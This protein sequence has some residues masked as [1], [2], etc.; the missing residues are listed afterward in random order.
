MFELK[1]L[2]LLPSTV[3][4]LVIIWGLLQRKKKSLKLPPGRMGWPFI[5]ETFGYLKPYLATT[6]GEFMEQHISRYGKI[7]KSY[8]FGD[9]AIVS[10]DAGLNRFILQ[11][12]GRL[13]ECS[14]PSSIGGILGKWSMLV[15]VGDMHRD[16]RMISL[17]FMSTSRLRTH[18]MPEVDKH[19]LLVLRS[20]KENSIF[21]AQNEAKKFTF[22][23]MAKHIMSIDPGKP[24]TEHLRKEYITFMKGVVSAPLNL[25]GTAYNRALKSRSTILKVIEHKMIERLK[26][27][28]NDREKV[29]DGDLLGW[30][31]KHS[32]LSIEQILD[33]ILSLLFAGHETSSVSI[34]L[35]IYFL[36]ACPKAVQELREEHLE[37]VRAK[38]R[39][40]ES[41]LNW[42]DYKQMEFTQC[43]ISE[44]LR[45][46]NVVRFLHRK[47]IKDVR[48]NGYDIPCGWKVLPVVA[49]VHLDP[50][51]YDKP[52]EF[53]PW[54]WQSKTSTDS[55]AFSNM[56]TGNNFMPF[57]GGPRLCAGSELAKL[58]MAVF[59]HHLVLNY[60]WELAE[61]DEPRVFPFVEFP[62]GLP[63]KA[64][65]A[66]FL[67]TFA[68]FVTLSGAL[69][70][71]VNY[72][73]V[74]DNLPT[75]DK[76]VTL[77]KSSY[78]GRIRLFAP[79]PDVFKALEGSRIQVILG[80]RNEDLSR[81]A[82]DQSYA[83]TWV[84]T[85]VVPHAS[86]IKFRC[87]SL[88]NEVIP[89]ELATYVLPAIQNLDAA[90]KAAHLMVPVTTAISMQVLGVS[91]PPS[92][93]VFSDSGIMGPITG[94]LASNGYPLMVNV[95]PY[96]AHAGD[97]VNIPHDY[98]LF[99]SNNIVVKDGKLGYQN[100]FDAMVDSVYSALEKARGPNVDIIVSETG[101]PSAGNGNIATIDNA[102]TY[103]TNLIAH[104]RSLSGTPKRPRKELET[105]LF[106]MFNEDLKSPGVEQNFGLYYPNMTPNL[107]Q[108]DFLSA[109]GW[110]LAAK[111]MNAV[112]EVYKIARAQTLIALCSTVPGY[113]FTVAFI[114][115][116]GRFKIQM[117]GFFFMTVSMFALAFPY[118]HWTQKKNRMGFVMMYALTFFFANFGLNATT[119]V[120]P[121]EI[122]PARLRSTCHGISAA[123]GK[124][125][126][127][128]CCIW[129]LIC[130]PEL[131]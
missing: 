30:V 87:I 116:I 4:P 120:V 121:A 46:G 125:W 118:N 36:Q 22:N 80:T 25:P 58:E 53:N 38:K 6:I 97:P 51:I 21:S 95:Y 45:L 107:F 19:T 48:Y 20:W 12:E 68:L 105:Y 74:A 127:Y 112:E 37:I 70:I 50:L 47:A 27:T 44:T 32:S 14:Y 55:S 84:N 122:F 65:K 98:A 69:K 54:R 26:E 2:L 16:M 76:V 71:G 109:D 18:L 56:K 35:A 119:F 24:E 88:G 102:Q 86:S 91:F 43:V 1:L 130:C 63:I 90:L 126:C 67:S 103:N 8:L 108:K 7:Y 61:P 104:L 17:N 3:L 111:T 78:I 110:I 83:A 92:Q 15:V 33:L 49:A 23:L 73:M 85:R 9:R 60:D 82:S 66:F 129:A 34:A 89:G 62:K 31:L 13:F 123:A 101:W 128:Y 113:W 94:F 124:G 99:K 72:G 57:G 64:M 96:F 117:M 29:E 42:D 75:P 28:N 79:N 77:F 10:A 52:Q 100:L 93:G 5:G 114:D 106:A 41:G 40:G 131:G 39:E 115:R 11:N 59:I 81:L